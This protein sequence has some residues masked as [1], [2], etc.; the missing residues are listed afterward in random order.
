[1][2]LDV[3]VR[4]G[5]LELRHV[6]VE[7]LAVERLGLRRPAV[8]GDR[9]LAAGSAGVGR[10]GTRD[11]GQAQAAYQQQPRRSAEAE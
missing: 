9:D 7:E 11:G 10:F 5:G 8:D 6:L 1:V 4:V 3:D 2:R